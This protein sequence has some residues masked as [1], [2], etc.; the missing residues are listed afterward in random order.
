MII[1]MSSE[2]GGVTPDG[3]G[4]TSCDD[5]AGTAD[6][7]SMTSSMHTELPSPDVVF[8]VSHAM[9]VE[10]LADGAI[11]PFSHRV[12]AIF[13]NVEYFPSG[14]DIHEDI[15][16]CWLYLPAKQ[17]SQ[18]VLPYDGLILP[19]SQGLHSRAPAFGP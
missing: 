11:R 16:I 3:A 15:A 19:V 9:H 17:S 10:E 5:G 7:L 8:P 12:Q 18:S 6:G 14:H 2:G 1:I 4:T 13:A